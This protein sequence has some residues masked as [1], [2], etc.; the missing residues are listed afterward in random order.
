MM[1]VPV[2][3]ERKAGVI[4]RRRGILAQCFHGLRGE[5]GATIVEFAYASMALFA[6]LF[7]VLELCLAVYSYDF[8]S[9]MARDGARY[10]IVRGAKCTGGTAFGCG[11][12]NSDV[13][14]YLRSE[15]FPA[16][17]TNNLTTHTYWYTSAAAPPNMTWTTLCATDTYSAACAVQGNA[18]QVVVNYAF[19][20]N[21]PY[22]KPFTINMSNSSQMVISQ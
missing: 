7:G 18:V 16:I 20:M 3:R 9:E 17:N 5:E 15:N 10:L 13:Q 19:T 11:S 4:V 2:Q 8:T 12:S 1:R 6:L 14:T 21:V 22:V